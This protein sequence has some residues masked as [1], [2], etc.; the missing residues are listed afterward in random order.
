M[1]ETKEKKK[2]PE[3]MIVSVAEGE[4]LRDIAISMFTALTGREPTESEL[5]LLELEL[6]EKD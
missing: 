5:R 6:S 1:S 4:D 3:R 2:K